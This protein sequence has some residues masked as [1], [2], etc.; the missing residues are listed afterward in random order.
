MSNDV[1]ATMAEAGTRSYD[2]YVPTGYTGDPAPL[3]VMLHG[4]LQDAAD[5][6]AGTRMNELVERHS[7]LPGRLPGAVHR[8]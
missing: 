8:R 4:G 6:A 5:F 2:L 1:N 3:L 7:F